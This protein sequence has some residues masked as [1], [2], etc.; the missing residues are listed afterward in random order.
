MLRN[1]SYWPS[2]SMAECWHKLRSRKALSIWNRRDKKSWW[3]TFITKNFFWRDF[4]FLPPNVSGFLIKLSSSQLVLVQTHKWD[5][6][7]AEIERVEIRRHSSHALRRKGAIASSLQLMR[8]R[9]VLGRSAHAGGFGIGPNGW[10]V[11]ALTA[12]AGWR[13]THAEME[14]E[15]EG[16]TDEKRIVGKQREIM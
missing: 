7:S 8:S 5:H 4:F 16:E 11:L 10:S 3:F 6:C 9:L 14:W 1:W 13:R 12:P 2:G 15:R